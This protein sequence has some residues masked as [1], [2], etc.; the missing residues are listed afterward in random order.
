MHDRQIMYCGNTSLFLMASIAVFLWRTC[1]VSATLVPPRACA[2]F[3]ANC[4]NIP[5]NE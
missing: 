3:L 5:H 1:T 2:Q 4:T